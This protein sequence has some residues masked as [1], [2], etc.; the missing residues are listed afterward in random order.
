LKS[1][2]GDQID[3]IFQNPKIKEEV[4]ESFPN[5]TEEMLDAIEEKHEF[6]TGDH[7]APQVTSHISVKTFQTKMSKHQS[8]VSLLSAVSKQDRKKFVS[9]VTEK[10]MVNIR[11]TY[12]IQRKCKIKRRKVMQPMSILF[13]DKPPSLYLKDIPLDAE[14]LEIGKHAS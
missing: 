6:L 3:S 14:L 8:Q 2:F 4:L 7:Q 9:S 13:A 11:K 1:S 10:P 5:L 12:G